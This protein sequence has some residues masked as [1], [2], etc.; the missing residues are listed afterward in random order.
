VKSNISWHGQTGKKITL[1]AAGGG[2]L[3]TGKN[4]P[5]KNNSYLKKM[6]TSERCS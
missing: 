1:E 5:F 6:Q 4:L 3:I 2:Y